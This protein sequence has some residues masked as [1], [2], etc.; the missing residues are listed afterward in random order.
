MTREPIQ[1]NCA[2]V[3]EIITTKT[4]STNDK[5][6][7]I[8]KTS[9]PTKSSRNTK[10]KPDPTKSYKQTT[11]SAKQTTPKDNGKSQSKATSTISMKQIT[12]GKPDTTPNSAERLSY[13]DRWVHITLLWW[14]LFKIKKNH[15]TNE[16]T[17]EIG[18]FVQLSDIHECFESMTLL[19]D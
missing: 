18:N 15:L 19:S 10:E 7:N 6:K 12:T 11:A 13:Y 17:K 8:K 16:S 1:P 4:T 9:K 5:N 14:C 2:N 3:D